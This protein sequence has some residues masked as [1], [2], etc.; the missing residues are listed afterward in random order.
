MKE[1]DGVRKQLTDKLVLVSAYQKKPEEVQGDVRQIL[2]LK[3]KNW[4]IAIIRTGGYTHLLT[5]A[6]QV[7]WEGDEDVR[8]KR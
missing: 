4:K 2:N 3:G 1:L 7:I 8:D 5:E 6:R